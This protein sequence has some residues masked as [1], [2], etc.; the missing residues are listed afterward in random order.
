MS[1]QQEEA[2]LFEEIKNSY[3]KSF[4][5][6]LS[7][8]GINPVIG[9]LMQFFRT[10]NRPLTQGEMKEELAISKSTISRNLKTM[11]QMDLLKINEILPIQIIGDKYQYSL[12]DNSLFYIT[13]SFLR[14][15]YLSF[16]QRKEENEIIF[17]KIKRLKKDKINKDE[18]EK[19]I[20]MIQEEN[21]VFAILEEKFDRMLKELEQDRLKFKST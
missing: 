12:V 15:I 9:K 8:S 14:K 7:N 4:D 21:V 13:M 5:N 16:K 2:S 17:K 6:W 18:L 20:Q 11:E 19:L 10:E 1:D 3:M